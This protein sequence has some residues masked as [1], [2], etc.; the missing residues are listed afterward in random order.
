MPDH[1]VV[2]QMC[3]HDEASWLALGPEEDYRTPTCSEIRKM[4][5][6]PD[7]TCPGNDMEGGG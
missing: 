4:D 6:C 1:R 2:V 3:G 5:K 7:P